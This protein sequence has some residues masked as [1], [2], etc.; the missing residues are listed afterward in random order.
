[1]SVLTFI[2]IELS[3]FC[4]CL[5]LFYSLLPHEGL[6]IV[7]K[8]VLLIMG[9]IFCGLSFGVGDCV[10]G[11]WKFL[12]Q[13]LNLSHSSDSAKSLTARPPGDSCGLSG[14]TVFAGCDVS[15]HRIYPC[16]T[17]TVPLFMALKRLW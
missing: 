1:M 15:T 5:Y 4:V 11:M 2:L 3:S 6:E 16:F 8:C 12:G 13:E 9:C 14:I 7:C 10:H 17:K